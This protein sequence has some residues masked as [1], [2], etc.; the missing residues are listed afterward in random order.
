MTT[1][2]LLS[3]H[4]I[5]ID[6]V[7]A[8]ADDPVRVLSESE[9]ADRGFDANIAVAVGGNVYGAADEEAVRRLR[10]NLWRRMR[11]PWDLCPAPV[12]GPCKE[13]KWME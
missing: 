9:R 10:S 5:A 2:D 11:L 12:T 7:L 1:K 3:V 13:Q 6:E 4:G 8:M